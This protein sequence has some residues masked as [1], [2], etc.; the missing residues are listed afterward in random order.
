MRCG[1]CKQVGHNRRNCVEPK[2]GLAVDV[3]CIVCYNNVTPGGNGSVKTE[4]GHTYCV[5]CF[6]E[7]MRH[8]N[9]CGYCRSEVSGPIQKKTLSQNE[10]VTLVEETVL[11]E[12]IN[13][14]IYTDFYAQVQQYIADVE[15]KTIN[16]RDKELI[17]SVCINLMNRIRLDYCIWVTGITVGER[18]AQE[19]EV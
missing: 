9:K 4:C 1:N 16:I 13:Q 6:V 19:Y 10:I 15:R 5:G 2:D 17:M 14:T 12:E 18:V 11:A 8:S 3:E 7:H